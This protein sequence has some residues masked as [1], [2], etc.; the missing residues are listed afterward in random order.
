MSARLY[1]F[2]N[3]HAAS[4]VCVA[5]RASRR[6][7]PPLKNVAVFWTIGTYQLLSCRHD[8]GDLKLPGLQSSECTA[9]LTAC[10]PLSGCTPVASIGHVPDQATRDHLLGH[11]REPVIHQHTKALTCHGPDLSQNTYNH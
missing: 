5:C 4:C 11:V 3:M 6:Q 7:V 10:S 2:N 8:R 9:P 1:A